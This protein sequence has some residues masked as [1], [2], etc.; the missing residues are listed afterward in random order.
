[1]RDDYQCVGEGLRVEGGF[2]PLPTVHAY[3]KAFHVP[4]F[5]VSEYLVSSE[6]TF[7]LAP[8]LVTFL[9]YRES[10]TDRQTD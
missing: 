3:D 6:L 10:E 8:I 7:F 4:L 2:S 9:R 1:M 5:L